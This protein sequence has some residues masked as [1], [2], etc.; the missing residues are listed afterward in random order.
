MRIPFGLAPAI[1]AAAVVVATPVQG[2][3]PGYYVDSVQAF[4]PRPIEVE[5]TSG[6]FT[7]SIRRTFP[8]STGARLLGI[9]EAAYP[10]R[11][12]L[13]R[14]A[15]DNAYEMGSD[16]SRAPL[17]W[18]QGPAESRIP[19][20]VT[21]GALSHYLKLTELYRERMFRRAG[22]RPIY[23]SELA[24][25][26]TIARREQF[27]LGSVEYHD[28]YVAQLTLAWVYDDGTFTPYTQGHRVV[29]LG[30]T[31]EILAVE[32]DGAAEEK[33]SISTHRGIGRH[34]QLLK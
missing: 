3:V 5:E 10:S 30:P 1:C 29:V 22:T 19:Y 6:E 33:V 12:T 17:W 13:I 24:Y 18:C 21:A 11:E 9:A 25:R 31:G 23:W 34:E 20:A 16:T 2:A 8:D 26:A 4:T 15:L 28:V 7:C 32:G 27:T 14:I